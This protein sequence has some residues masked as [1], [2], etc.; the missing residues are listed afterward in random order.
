MSHSAIADRYARAIFELG[1]EEG[2]AGTLVE[3]VRRFAEAYRSSPEL[4]SVLEN[5]LVPQAQ[6]KAVLEDVAQRVGVE[7]QALSAIRLLAERRKLAALPEIAVRLL[8]LTDR[9]AGIVRATVTSATELPEAYYGRLQTELETAT[10]R[11]IVLERKVDPSLIAGV[12]TRI[13]DNTIDGSVRGRLADIQ[14][15]L[16]G[17]G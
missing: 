11:R 14:Q 10:S 2:E 16:R 7:G 5:P 4:R 6:R 13:G 8:T 17:V 9:R 1:V 12:V 15:K 3:H